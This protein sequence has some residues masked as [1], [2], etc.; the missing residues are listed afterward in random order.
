[1]CIRDSNNSSEDISKSITEL[2]NYRIIDKKESWS[3]VVFTLCETVNLW[4]CK[5]V[6][7]YGSERNLWP[8]TGLNL[9]LEKAKWRYIAIQDH[10]DIWHPLKLEKQME[11]L[12]KNTE[13]V[14][15]GTKTIM[16]YEWDKKYFEYFLEEKSY[17]TL[18]PSLLFRYDGSFRYDTETT[19]YMCDAWSLKNNL[20][21]GERLI[22][23]L[24]ASLTLHLI[25]K[26]ST[27]YS[28]KWH[29]LTW[30]NIQRAYILHSPLYATLTLG[31]EIKRK[32]TYPL[33]QFF[34]LGKWIDILERIPFRIFGNKIKTTQ[35]DEWW[36]QYIR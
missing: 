36:N 22:Y 19:E 35:G 27:N 23:N 2:Q 24:D 16:Y 4:S 10:D 13:Y 5:S 25:K 8:Y 29:K 18:H 11:F 34:W 32:I 26:W 28:Y 6:K 9:L 15:C 30:R 1:M 31:W 17:Y 12:E 14:G 3:E 7:L 20:C 21:H 33:L